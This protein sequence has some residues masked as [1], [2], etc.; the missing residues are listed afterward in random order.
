MSE[1]A[2]WESP[3]LERIGHAGDVRGGLV[4][5]DTETTVGPEGSNPS[6]PVQ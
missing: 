3:E 5:L 6:G 1:K 2:G 4:P